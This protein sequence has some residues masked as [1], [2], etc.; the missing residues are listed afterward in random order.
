MTNIIKES[1][2]FETLKLAKRYCMSLTGYN[3]FKSGY[4]NV[5]LDY[6]YFTIR[7]RCYFSL[8]M[9]IAISANKQPDYLLFK[10]KRHIMIHKINIESEIQS[11]NFMI[12]QQQKII[13][14]S[15]KNMDELNSEITQLNILLE[16]QNARHSDI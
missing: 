4:F 15:I 13:N 9:F 14:E 2:E 11:R 7:P 1:I 3:N 8:R 6:F 10:N 12:E 5:G 16:K